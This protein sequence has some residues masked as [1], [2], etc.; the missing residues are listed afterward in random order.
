[1][2]LVVLAALSEPFLTSLC[3]L[4]LILEGTIPAGNP[5]AK[6]CVDNITSFAQPC[7][8]KSCVPQNS[9]FLLSFIKTTPPLRSCRRSGVEIAV[10]VGAYDPDFRWSPHPRPHHPDRAAAAAPAPPETARQEDEP[11][12]LRRGHRRGR[13]GP[14]ATTERCPQP[15]CDP[16]RT[17]EPRRGRAPARDRSRK[18]QRWSRERRRRQCCCET[19][20]STATS[21]GE[22]GLHFSR[23]ALEITLLGSTEMKF[24]SSKRKYYFL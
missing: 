17:R 20:A 12:E 4:Q 7:T 15:R 1:M 2:D 21:Y 19:R 23:C 13:R 6:I 16:Q 22:T 3:L 5:D 18:E 14:S 10:L 8:G 11:A 9:L 24:L